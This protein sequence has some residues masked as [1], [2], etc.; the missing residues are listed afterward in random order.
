MA[1]FKFDFQE[2][3]LQEKTVG[4]SEFGLVQSKK[5]FIVMKHQNDNFS[6]LFISRDKKESEDFFSDQVRMAEDFQ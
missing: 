2:T 1:N 3:V 4:N 5:T 6:T